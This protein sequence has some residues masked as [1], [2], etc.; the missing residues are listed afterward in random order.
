MSSLFDGLP[1]P[2]NTS[3]FEAAKAEK[4]A[5]SAAPQAP[6]GAASAA[7]LPRYGERESRGFVPRRA[8]DFGDGG[9][10]P[11]IHVPQYPRGMGKPGG[12]GGSQQTLALKVNG[13]GGADYGALHR[14]GHNRGKTTVHAEHGAIVPSLPHDGG[15]GGA[16]WERPTEEEEK[17][18]ARRTAAALQ[19]KVEKVLARSQP[20]AQVASVPRP[21]EAKYVKYTPAS[22]AGAGSSQRVI[23]ISQAHVDPLE[24]PKFK[25]KKVPRGPAE[26]PVPV[27][28][29]PPRKLT[30]Q[31]ALDWK[32]PPCVSNWKNNKGYT[33]P[34]DKRLAADGRGLQEVQINDNFA[35]LS[36]ALYVAEQKAREA[37]DMRSK[38]QKEILTKEKQK[39]ED[40]LRQLAQKARLERTG[41]AERTDAMGSGPAYEAPPPQAGGAEGGA[42]AGAGAGAPPLSLVDYGDEGGAVVGSPGEEERETKEEGELRRKREE[43]REERRRERERERR[44]EERERHGFK[45]SKL[46]RDRD[47][48]IS[49]KVALGQASVG[50]SAGGEALY[51]QRLFN[52]D[53]GMASGLAGEDT[54]NIYD[55][56]L[57][58]DK[59]GS[60]YR[61]TAG[62]ADDELYGQEETEKAIRTERFKAD[63]G[64]QGAE[65]GAG[66]ARGGARVGG[67][68]QFEMEKKAS[69]SGAA[70]AANAQ[71]EQDPFD[72]EG[73]IGDVRGGEGAAGR[74]NP[75]QGIG[76][77]GG[78]RANAGAAEFGSSSGRKKV[79]F[80]KGSN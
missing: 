74:K 24:P 48:D 14:Q 76:S 69:H 66:A 11:E 42:G 57:F 28:H 39:K 36:E 34:L 78:M 3:S 20:K 53:Q 13:Q 5:A 77:Q 2:V 30:Q 64:F 37:I 73:L 59:G 35:K 31:D 72:L 47:R 62:G 29:S 19:G 9:A 46:T 70:A 71:A 45:K 56:P 43:L 4:K 65:G 17:E 52:Q 44:L 33:V 63:K 7:N 40:E 79:N 50:A 26:A 18:T 8:K 15:E 49:E 23:R 68:V 75:L 32:I 38:I 10:Y 1:A 55:K 67:P 41:L 22:Q 6:S 12:G 25:Q 80:R 58:A 51:D 61:P 60:I 16:E 27:M 54:Y 21:G